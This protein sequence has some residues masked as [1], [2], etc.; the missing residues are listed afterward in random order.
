MRI[1]AHMPKKKN[2]PTLDLKPVLHIYCEGE[3]TEPNYFNGYIDRFFEANRRLKVVKIEPTK[4]NT[5]KQ[6]VDVAVAAQK[7]APDGDEFWVVYDRESEHKYKD[8]LH[9]NAYE[10]AQ[11]KGVFV[12]ISNVCFEIWLLL[13]FQNSSASY[14]NYDDLRTNNT[15]RAECKKRGLPDYDKGNQ[16]IFSKLNETEITQARDRAKKLNKL[17]EQAA[18]ASRTKPYQWNPYT[19][20]YKLLDAI[21]KFA[22][23][24]T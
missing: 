24:K 11:A 20:V 8:S 22:N 6:L 13:H 5:P 2:S 14:T 15:L 9:A 12:A 21:D 18:D 16:T 19:D 3:K 1:A 7:E 4:K 17:T 23:K 10:K